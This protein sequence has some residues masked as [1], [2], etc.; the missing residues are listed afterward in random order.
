MALLKYKNG[1]TW[2]AINALV[3]PAGPKGDTGATGATGQ[4]VPTGG[5]VSQALVKNTANNY[6][7]KWA[8]VYFT[9]GSVG[10]IWQG[11]TYNLNSWRAGTI[12]C[13]GAVSNV[14]DA[15]WWLVDSSGVSGTQT[16]VAFSLWNKKKPR[17]RNCASG[18]WSSWN[19]VRGM[20]WTYVGTATGTNSVALPTG[21]EWDTVFV[22]GYFGLN[23]TVCW[24]DTVPKIAL[25]TSDGIKYLHGSYT[26]TA[27]CLN[28]TTQITT[29]SVA[30]SS[31][32]FGGASAITNSYIK[33]WVK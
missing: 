16:Q 32:I 3:G 4:G 22:K 11:N 15:D 23:T 29:T 10:T 17:M 30:L 6:D 1:S 2:T 33:V 19:V 20:E 25:E 26:S 5:A 7:T 27:D 13:Q 14:P 18:T 8:G 9:D 12:L 24:A 21:Y 28:I 31:V